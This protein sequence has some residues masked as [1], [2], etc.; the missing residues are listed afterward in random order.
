[1]AGSDKETPVAGR[2]LLQSR[3][4]DEREGHMKRKICMIYTGGTIGMVPS[5]DGYQPKR[6]YFAD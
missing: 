2:T 5:S 4:Y 6:G 1:M 3:K